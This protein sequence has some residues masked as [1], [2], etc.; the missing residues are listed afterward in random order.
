[1]E[2]AD[3]Y[4]FAW[5]LYAVS[6]CFL[7]LVCWRITD[8]IGHADTR[9]VLRALGFTLLI[10][11]A[12]IDPQLP[13]WAPAIITILMESVTISLDAAINRL[14]PMLAAMV[15]AVTLSLCWRYLLR[16]KRLKNAN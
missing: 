3:D 11:P 7:M 12:Q 13:Y 1:M 9:S 2:V 16:K 14:W 8:F 10:L 15:F 4:F 6:A 5:C